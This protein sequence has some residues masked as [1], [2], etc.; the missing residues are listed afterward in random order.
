[1]HTK[2]KAL[3]YGGATSSYELDGTRSPIRLKSGQPQQF[4]VNRSDTG[5]A[6]NDKAFGELYALSVKSKTR[7]LDVGGAASFGARKWGAAAI[8]VTI[9]A[10]GL[11][12]L[13]IVVAEPL[14]PGE[15]AFIAPDNWGA[16][17]TQ[18]KIGDLFCFGVDPK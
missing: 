4:L 7:E 6:L 9:S 5:T 12:V 17:P 15:Y 3:G 13:K 16:A 1:M 11:D 8:P 14:P 2:L 18:Y 10:Y